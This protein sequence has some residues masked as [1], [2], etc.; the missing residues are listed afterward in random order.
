MIVKFVD[1]GNSTT[2]INKEYKDI[3]GLLEIIKRKGVINIFIDREGEKRVNGRIYDYEYSLLLDESGEF[4][5][6]LLVMLDSQNNNLTN[7]YI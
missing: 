6:T 2:I 3:I 7:S 5:E 4:R 1:K